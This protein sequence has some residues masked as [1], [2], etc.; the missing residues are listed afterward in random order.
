MKNIVYVGLKDGI[1]SVENESFP[2]KN[3]SAD[4]IKNICQ[5]TLNQLTLAVF[6]GV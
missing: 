3:L 6:L 2:I 4:L 5:K 1:V